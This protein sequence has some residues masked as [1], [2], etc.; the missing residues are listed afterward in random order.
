MVFELF[1]L[2]EVAFNDI[3]ASTKFLEKFVT[4]MVGLNRTAAS[5]WSRRS[6]WLTCP[7][8]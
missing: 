6:E 4:E 3:P 2:A 1:S 8:R 7:W 5:R